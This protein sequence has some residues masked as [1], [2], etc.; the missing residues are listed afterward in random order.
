MF[1]SN[2]L[3]QME[4]NVPRAFLFCPSE[5]ERPGM[6]GRS[7]ACRYHAMGIHVLE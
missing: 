4:R 3:D 5:G 7:D 2:K 6:C 1:L